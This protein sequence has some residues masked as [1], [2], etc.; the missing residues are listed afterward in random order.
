MDHNPETMHAAE[1][2]KAAVRIKI[3][4]VGGAG[5]K[6][7]ER[8]AGTPHPGTG[9][10]AVGSAAEVLAVAA[11]TERIAVEPRLLGGLGTGGDPERG[12]TA[13][14][15]HV[16]L[17][18]AACRGVSVVILV[19]GL[20]GGTGTGIAPVLARV[21]KEAGA[22]VIAFVTMPF[23]CE[24]NRRRAQAAQG[25]A[26]LKAEAD[27]VVCLPN[28]Q[29]FRLVD[30]NASVMETFKAINGLVADGVVGVW[31]LAACPKLMEVHLADLCA[32]LRTRHG[33]SVLATAEAAGPTRSRE[34]VD[35][36]LTHPMLE[37]GKALA[38]A[39][40]VLVSITGGPDLA[41]ADIRRI[42]E[43]LGA[44]TGRAQVLMGAVVEEGFREQLSITVVASRGDSSSSAREAS[45]TAGRASGG[46]DT[47]P[48][49]ASASARSH[50]R[51]TPPPPSLSPE[52]V[53]QMMAR[54]GGSPARPRKAST[55]L[56]Q[57]QLPLEIVSKGRFDKSEPTIYK[58]EDLDVPTYL[59]RGV[60]LN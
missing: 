22:L 44:Q 16:E 23:E 6:V 49:D 50:S 9:L 12:R 13:A 37:G 35:K 38:G 20:G 18:R 52:R 7:L 14:E 32:L 34:V 30:E 42:M 59:R 53:E 31:R 8:I 15:E 2:E 47:Q 39:D 56:R 1:A 48:L 51:F 54:Q 45:D 43:T 46:L 21:A 10:G 57:G 28:Q 24:G 17:L 36:L 19:A 4:G 27:G 33:G 3:F 58:G 29:I 5:L 25:L 55:K 41:M 60:A 40:T 11:A 26:E